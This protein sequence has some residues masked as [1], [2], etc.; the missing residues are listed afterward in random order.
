MGRV[1]PRL[2]PLGWRGAGEWLRH[3]WGW[4]SAV[5]ATPRPV[6]DPATVRGS[7]LRWMAEV[8]RTEC[9]DALESHR[10]G[11]RPP[12]PGDGAQEI[13]TTP[14]P[15]KRNVPDPFTQN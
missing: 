15:G 11:A 8:V 13:G 10:G 2:G 4:G 5:A 12:P 6:P 3:W 14:D 1:A 7:A 9:A